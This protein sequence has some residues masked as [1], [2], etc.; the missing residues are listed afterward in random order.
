MIKSIL[1]IFMTLSFFAVTANAKSLM[2]LKDFQIDQQDSKTIWVHYQGSKVKIENV[3]GKRF[4]VN[5]QVVVV[6][7]SDTMAQLEEKLK[8]AHKKSGNTSASLD[9]LFFTK[10]HAITPLFAG[11]IGGFLG[12]AVGDSMCKSKCP[13][14]ASAPGYVTPEAVAQ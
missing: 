7:E 11:L 6:S 10:A 3:D 4:K 5:N 9:D 13:Q 8:Q 12:F 1:S 2:K 14:P